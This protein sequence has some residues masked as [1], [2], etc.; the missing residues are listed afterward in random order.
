ME[1]ERNS[2]GD[3]KFVVKTTFVE[4][5]MEYEN[6]DRSLDGVSKKILELQTDL[7]REKAKEVKRLLKI[8]QEKVIEAKDFKNLEKKFKLLFGKNE[9]RR[10]YDNSLKV[11]INFFI[12]LRFCRFSIKETFKNF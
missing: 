12:L 6:N 4:S 1:N 9:G 5:N 3:S 7:E 10:I 8:Y 2:F 11:L